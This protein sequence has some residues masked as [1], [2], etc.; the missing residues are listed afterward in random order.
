MPP[1][2]LWLSGR[3]DI[4]AW[5]AGPGIECKG[6]RLVPTRANGLPAFAQYRPSGPGGA[7]QPWSLQVLRV[8]GGQVVEFTMFLDTEHVFP[9]F[10]IPMTLND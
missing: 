8:E 2:E 3:D 4:L 5:W 10:G 7:F 9:L 1:Y 6:S